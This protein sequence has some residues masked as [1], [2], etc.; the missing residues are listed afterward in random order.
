MVAAASLVACNSAPAA[1]VTV[2]SPLTQDFGPVPFSEAI[3][4][5]NSVLPELGA[6][7]TSPVDGVVVRWRMLDAAGGP[8]K[9]RVLRPAGGTSYIGLGKSDP[10]IPAGPS[11]QTFPA[12]LPIKAGDTIGLDNHAETGDQIGVFILPGS[13]GPFYDYWEPQISEG[14]ATPYKASVES[15]ELAF[16]ADVQPPPTVTAIAPASGTTAGGIAVTITGTDFEGASAVKFGTTPAQSF[17]VNSESTITAVAPAAATATGVP[18]SVTTVAGTASS[19]EPFSYTTPPA[20][21]TPAPAPATATC[22]VPKLGGKTLK[23]AKKRIRAADCK[24]G[25]VTKRDGATARDGEVL[26]QFPKA[27]ANVPAKT[28]VKVTLSPS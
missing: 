8:F 23:S 10:E 19:S 9:L 26:K 12:D 13:S 16:N 7:V 6:H 25:K 21:P 24:V 17:T 28:K 3:T 2:G 1:V 20:P 18:L 15:Y 14:I 22:R 11:L 27:G 5:T 4:T